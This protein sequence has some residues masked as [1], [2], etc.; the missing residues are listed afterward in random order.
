MINKENYTFEE[1]VQMEAPFRVLIIAPVGGTETFRKRLVDFFESHGLEWHMRNTPSETSCLFNIRTGASIDLMP[2][3]LCKNDSYLR[4]HHYDL[5]VMDWTTLV[6]S[7]QENYA[8]RI[9]QIGE[10]IRLFSEV[11][12]PKS[13]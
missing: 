3:H 2:E 7:F 5:I 12:K 4:G 1:L 11:I 9:F 8:M 6:Q 13:Y 10:E